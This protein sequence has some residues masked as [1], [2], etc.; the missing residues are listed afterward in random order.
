MH[1]TVQCEIEKSQSSCNYKMLKWI[2]SVL[3]TQRGTIYKR[4]ASC[5]EL[6]H[7]FADTFR[8]GNF[9]Y[10]DL[11]HSDIYLPRKFILFQKIKRLANTKR[12]KNTLTERR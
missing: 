9:I 10:K 7:G 1:T 11:N 4:T 5:Y 8:L 6:R 3:P 12:F 2:H